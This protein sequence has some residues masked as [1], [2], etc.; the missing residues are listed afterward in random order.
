MRITFVLPC[1]PWRPIGGFRVVY[2]FANHLASRGHQVAVVHARRLANRFV[3][4]PSSLYRLW[5][6]KA[7]YWRDRLFR[8]EIRWQ[9]VDDRVRLIYVEEPLADAVPEADVVFATSWDTVE[10]VVGYPEGKG[11]KLHLAQESPVNVGVP[12]DLAEGLWRAPLRTVVVSRWLYTLGE[13]LRGKDIFHVP[14][15]IDHAKYRILKPIS[16]RP[17]RVA[18]L[19]SLAPNKGSR[20]GIE[21]LTIAKEKCPEMRAVLFGIPRRPKTLPAWIEY[22]RDPRQEW[23]VSEIYNG[24]SVYLCSTWSEGFSLPAAEAMDCGCAVVA[25]DCGGNRDYAVNGRTA[26]VSP[27]QNPGLLAENLVRVLADESLRN[28]LAQ[29]GRQEIQRFT[30]ERSTTLLEQAIGDCTP[31]GCP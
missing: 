16:L 18:M 14:I 21:A 9:S 10:Y 19:F 8:P 11:D 30:W 20:D 28:R 15:A 24:S 6:G 5:R 27:P 23:L 3:A 22:R 12:R 26:L 13:Q 4:P 17:K 2:E 31:A 25:T 1:Y 7:A 29:V